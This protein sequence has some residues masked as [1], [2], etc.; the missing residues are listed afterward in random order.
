MLIGSDALEQVVGGGTPESGD[1]K[2]FPS[3]KDIMQN[4]GISGLNISDKVYL[5]SDCPSFLKLDDKA[6][7]ES[8]DG[9]IVH[10]DDCAG[11]KDNQGSFIRIGGKAQGVTGY[12][13]GR[14]DMGQ[15]HLV[16]GEELTNLMDSI[17]NSFVELGDAI[18]NLSAI[19]TGAG[20]SGP[21]SGGP[22]NVVAIEAWIAGVETIRA[23]L[24]DLLMKPEE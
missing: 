12:V 21:I 19:P 18:L 17:C 5:S 20:P 14:E 16:Y 3:I 4:P 6:H 13:F 24:C 15:Q 22:P 2:P 23:R 10:L 9:A 1:P 11:M 7:L 8:C